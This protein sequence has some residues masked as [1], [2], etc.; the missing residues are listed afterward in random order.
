MIA[1]GSVLEDLI[2]K[3][4][5]A[6]FQFGRALFRKEAPSMAINKNAY[7][8][9]GHPSALNQPPNHCVH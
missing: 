8:L 6:I 2:T 1:C 4:N 3:I 9:Y 7:L 5:S